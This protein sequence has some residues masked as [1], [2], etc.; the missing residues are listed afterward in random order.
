MKN[1][2]HVYFF[3]YTTQ[4]FIYSEQ[5]GLEATCDAC[6]TLGLWFMKISHSGQM[7]MSVAVHAWACSSVTLMPV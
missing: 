1:Y 4:N 5:P 3:C 7:E 6:V 2:I